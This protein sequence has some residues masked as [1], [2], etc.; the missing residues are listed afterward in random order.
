MFSAKTWIAILITLV[1]Y[2]VGCNRNEA[3][4]DSLLGTW[5]TDDPKYAERYLEIAPDKIVFGAPG[6]EATAWKVTG[7]T[8]SRSESG[9]TECIIRYTMDG[10]HTHSIP[11]TLDT[12]DVDVITLKNQGSMKWRKVSE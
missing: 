4:P 3:V 10:K 8:T 2:V 12:D 9:S 1:G 6:E 5:A 11:V 7:C